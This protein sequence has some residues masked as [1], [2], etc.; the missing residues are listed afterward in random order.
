MTSKLTRIFSVSS[1]SASLAALSEEI[2]SK[3]C[4]LVLSWAKCSFISSKCCW[5]LKENTIS[6][7]KFLSSARGRMIANDFVQCMTGVEV[8]YG[9]RWTWNLKGQSIIAIH[10]ATSVFTNIWGKRPLA[11]FVVFVV[12]CIF[13]FVFAHFSFKRPLVT[14]ASFV[15]SLKKLFYFR[16]YLYKMF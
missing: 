5:W 13:L 11:L 14:S 7:I 12:V 16:I 8:T 2:C 1:A 3:Y 4:L 15:S 9:Q 10:V 6:E